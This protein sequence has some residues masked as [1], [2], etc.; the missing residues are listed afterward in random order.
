MAGEV[1]AHAG[2]ARQQVGEP[3]G[4]DLEPC[5]SGA[6]PLRADL[7]D[8]SCPVE[9]LRVEDIL[10]VPHLHRR[11]LLVEDDDIRPAV[12]NEKEKFLDLAAPDIGFLGDGSCALHHRGGRYK[13]KGLCE[14]PQLPHRGVVLR[15]VPSGVEAGKDCSLPL[16][17]RDCCCLF[18]FRS[19][20]CIKLFCQGY[21]LISD[22]VSRQKPEYL[23]N[24][25]KDTDSSTRLHIFITVRRYTRY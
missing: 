2:K 24:A 14:G 23:E 4:G 20:R 5:L 3:C 6:C 17:C 15:P 19:P 25:K 21:L 13:A 11:Q 22:G 12:L 10:E 18:L 1:L 7:Q 16:L 8:D 9:H